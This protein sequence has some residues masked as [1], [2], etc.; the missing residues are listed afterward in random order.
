MK[1]K[2]NSF[3]AETRTDSDQDCGMRSIAF[4]YSTLVYQ[5]VGFLFVFDFFCV[6]DLCFSLYLKI[7][8]GI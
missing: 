6:L 5:V 4:C 3:A 7:Q 8:L 2:V 1:K